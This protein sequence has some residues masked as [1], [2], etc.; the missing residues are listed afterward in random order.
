MVQKATAC[1][2]LYVSLHV[3]I[4]V[5]VPSCLSNYCGVF[6]VSQ[7]GSIWPDNHHERTDNRLLSSGLAASLP[8]H[9]HHFLSHTLLHSFTLPRH[10]LPTPLQ[11]CHSL[12]AEISIIISSAVVRPLF[13]KPSPSLNEKLQSVYQ[14]YSTS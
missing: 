9:L 14:I 5:F 12:A 1:T 8:F 10:P 4:C 13:P 11:S 3:V 7:H 6:I 2:D